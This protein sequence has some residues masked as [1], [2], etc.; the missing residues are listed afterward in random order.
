MS[1]NFTAIT[2]RCKDKQKSLISQ[3][4]SQKYAFI[5]LLIIDF[6]KKQGCVSGLLRCSVAVLQLE[7]P[8]NPWWLSGFFS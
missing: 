4:F 1:V 5:P 7:N 3:T 2:F 8:D 6:H